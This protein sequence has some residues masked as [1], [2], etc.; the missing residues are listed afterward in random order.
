VASKKGFWFNSFSLLLGLWV[1]VSPW[2]VSETAVPPISVSMH[3]SGALAALGA[4]VAALRRADTWQ[5]LV[6]LAAAWLVVSPWVLGFGENPMRQSLFYGVL[7][8]ACAI[9]VLF[10]KWSAANATSSAR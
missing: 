3:V 2:A 9:T 4:A 1:M 8:G 6:V 7:I 5:Y 10:Q